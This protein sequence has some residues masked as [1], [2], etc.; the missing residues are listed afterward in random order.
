M[1]ADALWHFMFL[2]TIAALRP[3]KLESATQA[4]GVCHDLR[5]SS[6][7]TGAGAFANHSLSLICRYELVCSALFSGC[8]VLVGLALESVRSRVG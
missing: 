5:S 2:Q 8:A 7:W 1:R 4:H 3:T 6:P